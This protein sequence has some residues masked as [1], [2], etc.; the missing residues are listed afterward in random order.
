MGVNQRECG[1]GQS[2]GVWWGSIR[3][4]V[5]GV[6]QRECGGGQSEARRAAQVW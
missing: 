6:N 5:V 2:E 4:S 3:G 1:G